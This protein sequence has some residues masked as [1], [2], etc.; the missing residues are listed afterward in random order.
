MKGLDS[1]ET[2]KKRLVISSK[3]VEKENT[4]IKRVAYL[5]M[6]EMETE[7]SLINWL[8]SCHN[9]N[10]SL[11]GCLSHLFVRTPTKWSSLVL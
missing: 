9:R 5:V 11:R 2:H 1:V 6:L 10:T 7:Y 4:K 8:F 3:T